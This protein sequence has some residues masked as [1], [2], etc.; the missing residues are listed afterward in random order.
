[1]AMHRLNERPLTFDCAGDTLLGIVAIPPAALSSG[2][3]KIGVLIL[4]GGRQYRVGSHR[5]FVALARRLAGADFCSLRVDVRGM[6]DS[7]GEQ[8]PFDALDDDIDAALNAF[9]AAC[10]QLERVA[11]WGLCD[12]ATAAMLYWQRR[13]DPRIA[14]CCLVNPWFH[15]PVQAAR[16]RLRHYYTARFIDRGFWRKLLHGKVNP[17]HA[18]RGYLQSWRSARQRQSP[19]RFHREMLAG[20]AAFEAPLLLLLS[21]NDLTA[22][23]F[24]DGLATAGALPLLSRANV[25][26]HTVADADHTFSRRLWQMEAETVMVEWLG[27]IAK[28]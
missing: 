23:E 13:R 18:L 11:I 6:G 20:L 14:A 25:R 12:A 9:F 15:S 2:A 16:V 26:Q 8:R 3:P 27:K 19:Q 22:K 7:C 28:N 10:P 1:M 24:V 17:W 21:A 4:V 5:Q